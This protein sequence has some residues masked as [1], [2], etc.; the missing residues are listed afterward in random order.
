MRSHMLMEA[1]DPERREGGIKPGGAWQPP[2]E[3]QVV[4][5]VEL[6]G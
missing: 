3:S 1:K 6:N 5:P 2:L 4:K